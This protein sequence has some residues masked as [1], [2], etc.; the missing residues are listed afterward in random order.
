[1]VRI[2][3]MKTI[4]K[5]WGHEIIIDHNE[6]YALKDIFLKAG[7]RSSLQSHKIKLETIFILNG[8]LELETWDENNNLTVETYETNEAYTI[9]PGKRHRV[10]ALED[11]RVLEVS[12][13]ELSD[14]IRHEDDF[15]RT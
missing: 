5:P 10:T 13:P 14:V 15:G 1:M 3:N 11:C 12:T 2:K 7:I 4:E 9:S 6:K 8:R